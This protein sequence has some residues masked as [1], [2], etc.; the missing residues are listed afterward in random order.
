MLKVMPRHPTWV[1]INF[2]TEDGLN[3]VTLEIDVKMLD[4]DKFSIDQNVLDNEG[5]TLEYS[6]IVPVKALK[7]IRSYQA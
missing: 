2:E 3:I 7:I 4:K 1:G 5:D 6:G